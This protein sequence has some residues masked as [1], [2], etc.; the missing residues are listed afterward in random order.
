MEDIPRLSGARLQSAVWTNFTSH[1]D[2][3][4]PDRS[5]VHRR[6]VCGFGDISASMRVVAWARNKDL[7]EFVAYC[8]ALGTPAEMALLW[9]LIRQDT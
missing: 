2:M 4:Y 6:F 1:R 9:W 5:T 7:Q 8:T 3:D